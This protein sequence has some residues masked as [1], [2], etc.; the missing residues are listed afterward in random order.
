M[1]QKKLR[2][3]RRAAGIPV[4]KVQKPVTP[5]HAAAAKDV[6]QQLEKQRAIAPVAVEP[7]QAKAGSAEAE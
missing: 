1:V 5:Q 3:R 7:T 2:Q 6:K 4:P